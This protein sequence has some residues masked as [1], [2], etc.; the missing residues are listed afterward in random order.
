M[1]VL[2]VDDAA[3]A[4]HGPV[5]KRALDQLRQTYTIGKEEY[6]TFQFLGRRVIQNRDYSIEVDQHE[7]IKALE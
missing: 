4:G 1:L 6:G 3:Y 5:W 7:Y 2:H